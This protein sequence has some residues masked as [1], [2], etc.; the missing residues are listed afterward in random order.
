MGIAGYNDRDRS[1]NERM[2]DELSSSL[3]ISYL[4]KEKFRD[5]TPQNKSENRILRTFNPESTI[6]PE[7]VGNFEKELKVLVEAYRSIPKN[8]VCN[9]PYS[10]C[11]FDKAKEQYKKI[12]CLLTDIFH[13]DITYYEDN[14]FTLYFLCTNDEKASKKSL[15]RFLNDVLLCKVDEAKKITDVHRKFKKEYEY[16]KQ[17]LYKLKGE[18]GQVESVLKTFGK[19]KR[20]VEKKSDIESMK[21]LEGVYLEKKD[22]IEKAI[23]S[24]ER[25]LSNNE[26]EY[27]DIIRLFKSEAII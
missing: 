14:F 24:V 5:V 16:K 8:A 1:N 2:F 15:C 21:I 27:E 10:D 19:V 25:F 6:P 12:I 22:N 18:R 20:G 4:K 7:Y 13:V 9:R 26:Q 23:V 3:G 11:Y 17:E